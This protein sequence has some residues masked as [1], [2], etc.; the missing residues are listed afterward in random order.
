MSISVAFLE[1]ELSENLGLE[2]CIYSFTASQPHLLIS[3]KRIRPKVKLLF[4]FLQHGS[5]FHFVLAKKW[6]KK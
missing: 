2:L 1:H 5:N 6:L 3:K 4:L